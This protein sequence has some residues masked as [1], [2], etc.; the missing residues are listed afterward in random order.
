[1]TRVDF[2]SILWI[3]ILLIVT[4]GCSPQQVVATN[5]VTHI[6]SPSVTATVP[7]AQELIAPQII[8]IRP[9]QAVPGSEITVTGSGGY[10][11]DSCGGYIEGAREFKL[12]LD[13]EPVSNLSCYVN[14]WEGKLVLQDT[15]SVGK[16]CLSV[17]MDK[18][19]FEFQ[20]T[21]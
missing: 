2:V 19:Q 9:A 16:H 11:R 7:C 6:P 21:E 20:I 3:G 14:H 12:Y 5:A 18:C 8:E 1:M 17:E 15:L 4:T 13:N 10:V